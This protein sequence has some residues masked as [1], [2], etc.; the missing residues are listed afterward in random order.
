MGLLYY[1]TSIKSNQLGN[2]HFVYSSCV[3]LDYKVNTVYTEQKNELKGTALTMVIFKMVSQQTM[4]AH[5]CRFL[6]TLEYLTMLTKAMKISRYLVNIYSRMLLIQSS[7]KRTLA[8]TL[9]V[10]AKLFGL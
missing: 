4:R 5:E 9:L 8:V 3:W 7:Y 2:L 1:D 10:A 6:S